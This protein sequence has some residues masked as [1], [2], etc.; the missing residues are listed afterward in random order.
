MGLGALGVADG[1]SADDE[2]DWLAG[3]VVELPAVLDALAD[4]ESSAG[5]PSLEPGAEAAKCSMAASYIR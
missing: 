2:S 1:V 5:G 4:P 3:G